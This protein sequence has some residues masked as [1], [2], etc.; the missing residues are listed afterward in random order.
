MASSTC[1]TYHSPRS[2]GLRRGSD[3]RPGSIM[4]QTSRRDDGSTLDQ[5]RARIAT[6][7]GIQANRPSPPSGGDDLLTA[8]LSTFA[9]NNSEPRIGDRLG[10]FT[11][12]AEIGCGGMGVV[13]R[14]TDDDT[15]E[16]VALKV[17][18]RADRK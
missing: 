8:T 18:P 2:T 3:Q 14:A 10:R 6:W 13:Y 12:A 16:P 15:G 4:D 1:P 9:R 5:D 7:L 11:I 17:V